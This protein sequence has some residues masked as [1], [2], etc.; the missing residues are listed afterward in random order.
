MAD[1]SFLNDT[2]HTKRNIYHIWQLICSLIPENELE[3][4]AK[5]NSYKE[6]KPL[7]WRGGFF[8]LSHRFIFYFDASPILMAKIFLA[9]S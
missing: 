1:I 3:L 9:S 8:I 5:L 7:H 2:E 4:L 6:K